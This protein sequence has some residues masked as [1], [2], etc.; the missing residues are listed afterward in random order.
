VV[1]ADEA[2]ALRRADLAGLMAAPGRG[3]VTADVL[4]LALGR[5]RWR[6]SAAGRGVDLST[7]FVVP[8]TVC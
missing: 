4:V 8:G 3:L 6:A 1:D 5:P 7:F 2:V